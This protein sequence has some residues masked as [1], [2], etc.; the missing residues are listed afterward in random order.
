MIKH[1]AD[2]NSIKPKTAIS[3]LGNSF[4]RYANLNNKS[5]LLCKYDSRLDIFRA[6]LSPST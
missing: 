5:P 1:A 4:K 2:N 6:N 3:S